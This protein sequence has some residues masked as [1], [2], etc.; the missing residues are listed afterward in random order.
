MNCISWYE[1]YI[2]G[3]HIVEGLINEKYALTFID[4]NDLVP[5]MEMIGQFILWTF[6]IL[7]YQIK[8]KL[9]IGGELFS[10]RIYTFSP[11]SSSIGITYQKRVH[12]SN[13]KIFYIFSVLL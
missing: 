11:L 6:S 13:Y 10:K 9:L 1:E 7:I 5:I 4:I 12:L 2:A 8:G 3:F